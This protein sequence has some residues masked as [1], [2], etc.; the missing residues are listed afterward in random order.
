MWD[1]NENKTGQSIM[2]MVLSRTE[3]FSVTEAGG[4]FISAVDPNVS[5]SIPKKAISGTLHASLKV[6]IVYEGCP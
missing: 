4:N 1:L 6:I 2:G 5:L 3:S